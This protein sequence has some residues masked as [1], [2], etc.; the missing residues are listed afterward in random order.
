MDNRKD[1]EYYIRN[2]LENIDIIISYTKG[3]SYEGFVDI[4]FWI[5]K[6]R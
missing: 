1:D 4:R 3:L 6:F 2:V 5:I